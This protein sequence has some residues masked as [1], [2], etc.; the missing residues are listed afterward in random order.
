[1]SRF[2]STFYQ[3]FY[4]DPRTRVTNREEMQ[5]R[6]RAIAGL[7]QHLEIPVARI[8]DAGCGLGLMRQPLLKA[9]PAATYIGIEV[10]EHVC[11][12]YGWIQA[13]I[14]DVKLRGR[15]DLIVC[16]DVLQYLSD[17]D[18]ARA[19]ANL[20]RLCRGALYFHAPTLE[21][22]QRNADRSCSDSE[23]RLRGV[24]WYRSR[25]QRHFRHAGFGIY[26]R[27]GVPIVQWALEQAEASA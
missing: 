11:A 18:A 23:I 6:A 19:L 10:S 25:L 15:F 8:L 26:V 12:R 16:Y 2:D 5:V 4:L 22:W 3:R 14:A 9:F 21:D 17:R 24:E 20:A 13:S 7:V 27:R 1:M